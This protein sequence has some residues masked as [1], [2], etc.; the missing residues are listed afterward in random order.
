MLPPI[1]LY[2]LFPAHYRALAYQLSKREDFRRCEAGGFSSR[3]VEQLAAAVWAALP[4]GLKALVE[5]ALIALRAC[6]LCLL[7]V[8]AMA[9][10]LLVGLTGVGRELWLDQLV[11]TLQQSGPA[12]IKWGQ[13]ASTRPDLFPADV[14]DRLEQLQTSAPQH[15]LAASLS[16]VHAAFGQDVSDQF[17]HANGL[18]LIARAHQLV[19]EGHNWCHDQAVVTVFSAPN[20]CYRCGNRAA[21]MEVSEGMATSFLQFEPAPRRGEP[22]A[23]RRTPDYFL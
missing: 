22:D 4:Q 18:S 9:A 15:S 3:A 17:N 10:T 13:W 19:M 11:W 21:I 5:E 23:S 2:I 1:L 7:F 14:C 8:P 16:A 20:Y 6:Y 12:F